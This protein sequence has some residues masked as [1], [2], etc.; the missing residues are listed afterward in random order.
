M[1]VRLRFA[2][3]ANALNVATDSLF[4]RLGLSFLVPLFLHGILLSI[5]LWVGFF[6][7]GH[8]NFFKVGWIISRLVILWLFVSFGKW[9]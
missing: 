1:C 8:L 7:I 9:P 5:I 4:F 6:L 3:R 2:S